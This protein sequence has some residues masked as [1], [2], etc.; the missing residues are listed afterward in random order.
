M[1][2]QL[3]YSPNELANLASSID[4][5]TSA[6]WTKRTC[7]LNTETWQEDSGKTNSSPH[8]R[9][10]EHGPNAP[11]AALAEPADGSYRSLDHRSERNAA[12]AGSRAGAPKGDPRRKVI[13]ILASRRTG[14]D[15]FGSGPWRRSRR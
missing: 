12:C 1:L 9:A 13:P 6:V 15:R 4:G 14:I 7:T 10:P 2:C 8:R 3:S 5:Y 11:V